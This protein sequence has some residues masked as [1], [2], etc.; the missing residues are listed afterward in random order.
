MALGAK[1]GRGYAFVSGINNLG[2]EEMDSTNLSEAAFEP[3]ETSGDDDDIDDGHMAERGNKVYD[4][5][6]VCFEVLYVECIKPGQ[7]G[8]TDAE[9]VGI[10]SSNV[11]IR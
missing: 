3:V 4:E 10:H 2:R 9:K 8:G 6:L 1:Q 11:T 5:L 7:G